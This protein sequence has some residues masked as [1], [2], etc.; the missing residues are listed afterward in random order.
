[1]SISWIEYKGKNILYMQYKGKTKE[2]MLQMLEEIAEI[3]IKSEE[4]LLTLDDFEGAFAF[5]EFMKKAKELD[6][7]IFSK[8]TKRGA[9]LGVKGIKKILLKAF[10]SI[11]LVQV[12]PFDTKEEALEYLVKD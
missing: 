1:M 6:K 8:K 9:I 2:E 3:H 5:D 11:T 4:K 10:N 7:E 12:Q